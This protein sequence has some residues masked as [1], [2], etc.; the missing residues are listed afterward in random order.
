[1]IYIIITSSIVNKFAKSAASRS[2]DIRKQRYISCISQL[3]RL[4]D[5]DIKNNIIKPIIVEGNGKRKT[6][7]DDLNCDVFYTNTNITNDGRKGGK[8]Y[9]KGWNETSDIRKV[10][11]AYNIQ[12]EDMIIKITG[13]Y[14]LNKYD[15]INTVKTN[16]GKK[17]AFLKFYNICTREYANND[18]ILGLF[19]LR[20]KYLKIFQYY[21]PQGNPEKRFANF[22]RGQGKRNR[23]RIMAITTSMNLQICSGNRHR[24]RYC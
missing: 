12:D 21:K 20:C 9:H 2:I 7:L 6:Y 14:M 1:M 8:S 15:F 23:C 24:I 11:R 16:L 3:L 18:C 10:I 13:R 4:I 17:D 22:V 19:A 5:L